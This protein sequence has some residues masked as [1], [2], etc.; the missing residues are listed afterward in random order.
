MSL[1]F[2]HRQPTVVL[3]FCH[4]CQTLIWW[5]K[6][7]TDKKD[8]KQKMKIG[9]CQLRLH[10]RLHHCLWRTR[11]WM[12][13][14]A[15]WTPYEK[16]LMKICNINDLRKSF[17]QYFVN[18]FFCQFSFGL[19]VYLQNVPTKIKNATSPLLHFFPQ[20]PSHPPNQPPLPPAWPTP[21]ACPGLPPLPPL[22]L[23]PNLFELQIFF[24]SCQ[25]WQLRKIRDDCLIQPDQVLRFGRFCLRIPFGNY[26]LKKLRN[27]I[28]YRKYTCN[29]LFENHLLSFISQ[30]KLPFINTKIQRKNQFLH[31]FTLLIKSLNCVLSI[32]KLREREK[33]LPKFASFQMQVEV[34]KW[35]FKKKNVMNS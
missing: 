21:P 22:V 5:E 9:I 6:I 8:L 7:W 20:P 23:S 11:T 26:Y 14:W 24:Q 29:D 17:G 10:R 32:F 33:N 27:L 3:A 34:V 2:R 15:R 1:N 12:T 13:Y 31:T 19:W 4:Q 35:K 28:W 18:I 30:I 25:S 16:T